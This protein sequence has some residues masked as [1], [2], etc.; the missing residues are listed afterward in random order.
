MKGTFIV[1]NFTHRFYLS[2]LVRK[3]R[4]LKENKKDDKLSR[5]QSRVSSSSYECARKFHYSPA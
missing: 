5:G 1:L 3:Q 2:I 4:K